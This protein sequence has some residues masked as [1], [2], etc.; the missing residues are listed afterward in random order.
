MK[1]IL[2]I[3]AVILILVCIGFVGVYLIHSGKGQ[4][5]V[6]TSTNPF[7]FAGETGTTTSSG[8]GAISLQL[9]DGGQVDV[10]NFVPATQPVGAD[11]TNGYQITE[12]D[13]SSYSILYYPNNSGFLISLSQEPIGQARLDAEKFLQSKLNLT[14]DQFCKLQVQVFTSID[15]NETYAGQD[16][17]I[18]FCPGSVS[19]PS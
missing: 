13:T 17:G 12:N 15:V 7:G 3:G 18:S 6:A 16:L 11:V 4:A 5:P 9:K 14:Q 1:R 2:I 19:L 8:T 10:Q